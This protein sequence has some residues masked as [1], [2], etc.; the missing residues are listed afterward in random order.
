[1]SFSIWADLENE[2]QKATMTNE[3]KCIFV[4]AA[5]LYSCARTEVF[6][7]WDIGVLQLTALLS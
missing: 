6:T 5:L 4:L 2:L 3:P 1:M 7:M